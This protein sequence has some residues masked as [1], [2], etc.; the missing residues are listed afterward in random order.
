LHLL[1][2]HHI[3][4]LKLVEQVAKAHTTA[5][6]IVGGVIRDLYLGIPSNDFDF[7]VEGDA[8]QFAHACEP[9]LGGKV[10]VFEKFRTA[11]LAGLTAIS[12]L[13]E[14]DFASTRKETYSK[15]GALPAVSTAALQADLERR[16]FTINSIAVPLSALCRWAEQSQA[17]FDRLRPALV[18][19]RNGLEDLERRIIRCLHEKS[20]IDDPTRIFRAM[21]YKVRIAGE[22]EKDT[23]SYIVRALQGGCLDTVS[24]TRKLAELKRIMAES[25]CADTLGELARLGVFSCWPFISEQAVP[26]LL[27]ALRALQAA[28]QRRL[29]PELLFE[30]FLRLVLC[31]TPISER[32]HFMQRLALSKQRR[33][34]IENDL[35]SIQSG[36]NPEIQSEAGRI[37]ADLLAR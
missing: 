33:R 25:L 6:F 28:D 2:P 1:S 26:R 19:P 32:A 16:D 11:K 34:S 8:P 23:R 27:E 5:V 9:A 3:K 15:P 14:V 13:V 12:S 21:R 31:L 10:K 37:V 18:D 7:V 24:E 35:P 29:N 4:L 22:L 20:F 17:G 36:H 30:V